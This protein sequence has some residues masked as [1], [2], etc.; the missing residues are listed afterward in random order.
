MREIFSL[1]FLLTACGLTWGQA[2]IFA[3][4]NQPEINVIAVMV[5]L[6]L[7]AYVFAYVGY[8][9]SVSKPIRLALT[10]IGGGQCLLLVVVMAL[11]ITGK[12]FGISIDGPGYMVLFVY[13]IAFGIYAAVLGDLIHDS[14]STNSTQ[15]G[16][17][18]RERGRQ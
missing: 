9:G 13:V 10:F 14:D 1:L 16:R 15:T 7:I 6:T 11:S 3:S 18:A 17:R 8:G 12:A 4:S 5:A 2:G